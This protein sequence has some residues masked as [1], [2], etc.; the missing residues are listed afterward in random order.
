MGGYAR[1]YTTLRRLRDGE[2]IDLG[3]IFVKMDEGD[4]GPGD[5]YI[6]ERNT[7]PKFL[8]AAS[9]DEERGYIVP[10]D[11]HNYVFNFDECVKVC[12]A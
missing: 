8:T 4:I 3:G 10:I 12:E 5:M 6:A 1:E 9:I 2:T 11:L 7:G